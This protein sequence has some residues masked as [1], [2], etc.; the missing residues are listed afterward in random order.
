MA[1]PAHTSLVIE[2]RQI[3]EARR[4]VGMLGSQLPA[5]ESPEL[6]GTMAPPALL[7]LVYR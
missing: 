4:R 7:P 3:V 5:H 6:A 1:P 2:C